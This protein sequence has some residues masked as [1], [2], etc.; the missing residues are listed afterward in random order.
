MATRVADVLRLAAGRLAASASP[1]LDAELLLADVLACPRLAFFREPERVLAATELERYEALLAARMAGVPV[2]YLLGRA[3]FWSLTLE[4]TPA[5]LIPRADTEILVEAALECAGTATLFADLGT[6]SGAIALALAQERPLARI[7]AVERDAAAIAVAARNCARL[8][9]NRVYL[10]RGDWLGP[11]ASGRFDAIVANPP[12]VA[13][14]E[15]V[16]LAAE[17]FHEPAVA[18]FAAD[19]G[20]ADL[21]SIIAQ[22]RRVLRAGAW[23]LLEHG[24]AQA[25]A[26]AARFAACGYEAIHTRRDLAGLERVTAGRWP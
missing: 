15:Q 2:A 5:V 23:L 26:V 3:E 11:L 1:R 10:V 4:V 21:Q 9:A 25:A 16:T 22:A 19:G 17:L 18:L 6:G 7:V 13:A 14:D 24:A 8:G 12:Y 20:L